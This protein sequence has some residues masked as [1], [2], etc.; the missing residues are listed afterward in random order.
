MNS[1]IEVIAYYLPQF[2]PI[3]ENNSWWGQGFTEWTNV[4]KARPLYR[5]HYQPKIPADLGFYDLRNPETRE[6]QAE[7][8]RKAGIGGFCYWHYWFGNGKRLLERPFNDVLQSG[9]PKFPF[10]LG[11]AN[12]S[13]KAKV[14][15]DDGGKKDKTLVE[16]L[17]PGVEDNEHHFF[18]LLDAF[19]D[20]RYIRIEGKP[21]FLIY[22]PFQFAEIK[23][24][25]AEWNALAKEVGL[26]DGFHFVAQIDNAEQKDILEGYGF[27][28]FVYA[29]RLLAAYW[30]QSKITR[31]ISK[32]KRV[33][34]GTPLIIDYALAVEGFVD[35]E[36]DG[37]ENVMPT[38]IPNWDHSPRSG[39]RAV[40]LDNSTPDLFRNNVRAAMNSVKHKR[41]CNKIIMLKSWNEWGEG[42]YMEPDL[43]FGTG[44]IEAL[45]LELENWE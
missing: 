7:L 40:V 14:W 12:E 45:R 11:W 2:H 16:Q 29:P 28:A 24:F 8:A 43:K 19:R 9:A 34:R 20:S 15:A 44:Y 36:E 26:S 3:P 1:N 39:N 13:W 30:R 41:N 18:S 5:S 35:N 23:G 31:L 25:L 21:F 33:M 22:K 38:I 10:C 4:A 6:D 27:S 37:L 32:I 17:Y 42:N